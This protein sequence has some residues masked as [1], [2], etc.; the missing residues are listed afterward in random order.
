VEEIPIDDTLDERSVRWAVRVLTAI[1][2]TSELDALLGGDSER[3]LRQLARALELRHPLSTAQWWRVWVLLRAGTQDEH[4]GWADEFTTLS[5][6]PASET[7]RGVDAVEKAIASVVPPGARRLEMLRPRQRMLAVRL[8]VRARQSMRRPVGSARSWNRTVQRW[9]RG[10]RIVSPLAPEVRNA[11]ALLV[12]HASLYARRAGAVS[13]LGGASWNELEI[14][15]QRSDE[16]LSAR[17][18]RSL[19]R[20]AELALLDSRVG[21]SDRDQRALYGAQRVEM[22]RHIASARAWADTG[23]SAA[24]P[25]RG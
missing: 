7:R 2:G 19:I 11:L 18:W 23:L 15:A 14:W 6:M 21:I 24:D 16:G 12:F 4:F 13:R 5:G 10:P 17:A 3:E 9:R 20:T 8:L 25:R 1:W 22:F